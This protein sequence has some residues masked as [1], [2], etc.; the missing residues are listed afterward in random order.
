MACSW[1][2]DC[3]P[4]GI[5]ITCFRKG[6]LARACKLSFADWPDEATLPG[7][8]LLTYLLDTEKAKRC[9]DSVILP[10]ALV[11]G[12]DEDNGRTRSPRRAYAR[13]SP[14]ISN[15]LPTREPVP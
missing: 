12:L 15:D 10:H 6:L 9:G 7:R 4:D 5:A 3:T 1:T 11:A 14:D 13:Q 2:N 8:D